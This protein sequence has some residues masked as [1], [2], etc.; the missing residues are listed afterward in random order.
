M[1]VCSYSVLKLQQQFAKPIYTA[2]FLGFE[3]QNILFLKMC[4]INARIYENGLSGKTPTR[5]F[6][7]SGAQF[8]TFWPVALFRIVSLFLKTYEQTYKVKI[9]LTW[10]FC[11]SEHLVW[12]RRYA[13][14][15]VDWRQNCPFFTFNEHLSFMSCPQYLYYKYEYYEYLYY[16]SYSHSSKV[17]KYELWTVYFRLHLPSCFGCMLLLL[18]VFGDD[19]F[20]FWHILHRRMCS[21]NVWKVTSSHIKVIRVCDWYDGMNFIMENE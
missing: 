10:P 2:Y 19:F 7:R 21:W 11:G 14:Y 13:W 20:G 17:T 8:I 1:D 6:I 4:I 15:E 3:L 12:K 9:S 18:F 16:R 5:A